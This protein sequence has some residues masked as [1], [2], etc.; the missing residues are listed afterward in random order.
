MTMRSNVR[1]AVAAAIV[2]TSAVALPGAAVAAP[3]PG[4]PAKL[5]AVTE[6]D[7]ATGRNMTYRVGPGEVAP[8]VLGVTNVGDAPVTGLVAQVRVFNDLDPAG[9]YENCWYAVDSNADSAWCEF[10]DQLAVD[11]TLAITAPVV[12]TAP[13]AQPDRLPAVVFRWLSK[14]W[15]DAHGGVQ[16]YA[17]GS[18]GQGT[19]AQRGTE[20][21]LTLEA[22]SLPLTES[23]NSIN[24][25]Y[26]GLTTPPTGQPTPTA[27]AT[28]SPTPSSTASATPTGAPATAPTA[29]PVTPGDGGAGGGLP[30]TGAQ[31]AT[32]AGVG[33]AL[34]LLGA[35]GYLV[36]RRRRTRFVA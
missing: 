25:A 4:D 35:A 9:R 18:A 33:A 21:T 34:L 27:T 26:V 22:R 2:A 31:T 29:A 24:F 10:P 20:G 7:P 5:A 16:A 1:L 13:N 6:R 12:A 36:A 14:E 3:A 19:T 23:K 32:V 17:D 15:V 30:V 11:A 8:V 28:A